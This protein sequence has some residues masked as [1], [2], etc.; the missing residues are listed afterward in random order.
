[1][2]RALVVFVVLCGAC[3]AR[4]EDC[5][6]A[7]LDDGVVAVLEGGRV[8]HGAIELGP[9]A[10]CERGGAHLA[11]ARARA[12]RARLGD[13]APKRVRIAWRPR[14]DDGPPID[15][16]ESI[17]DVIVVVD[18]SVPDVAWAHE[19]V[20]VAVFEARVSARDRHVDVRAKPTTTGP[21]PDARSSTH[22]GGPA[23][24]HDRPNRRAKR[25]V[26][27]VDRLRAAAEEGV[28]D[29]IA[30]TRVGP[31]DR[32]PA[33]NAASADWSAL[34]LA[35]LRF[36]PHPLGE[37]FAAE[38]SRA[39]PIAP[40]CLIDMLAGGEAEAPAALV[41]VWKRLC[42]EASEALDAWIPAPLRGALA[43][44]PKVR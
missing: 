26:R 6:G 44:E 37:R 14:V 4:P 25:P 11:F 8:H 42:P 16:I 43:P 2:I 15:R 40:R 12:A 24:S 35:D 31:I 30:S 36:D 3:R 27:P 10:R 18:V 19:L 21:T 5:P 7:I 9:V 22:A 32:P 17:G 41:T 23:P 20:H 29:Y 33:A 13:A 39:S 34:A 1:M 38:L 28:A